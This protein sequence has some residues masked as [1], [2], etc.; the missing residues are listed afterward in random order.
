MSQ[1]IIKWNDLLGK[2]MLFIVLVGLLT[3][4]LLRLPDSPM[5]R[6]AVVA[7]FGYMT[8]VTSLTISLQRFLQ[9]LK[10]PWVPLWALCLIHV[11]SPLLAWVVG[12]VFYPED[13][14]TRLGYLICA[15]IPAGVTSII[16]TSLTKGNVAVSLVTVTL[17]TLIVPI[18][19]PLYL[20]F[21]VGQNLQLDYAHMVVQLVCMITLPSLLGILLH[22]WTD[23]RVVNFAKGIGGLSSK[24]GFFMVIVINASIVAPAIEWNVA[25]MKTLFVTLFMVMFSY[26]LGY[27]GTLCLK[28]RSYAM[29]TT[30]IY[31]VGLRNLSF[32]LVLALSY[33]PP[34]A[35]IPVTLGMLFQQPIAALIPHIYKQ[36][37]TSPLGKTA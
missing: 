1:H 25:L 19:M 20:R 33:F 24:L 17:D 16:W 30:M 34:A 36:P 12:Y 2:N 13:F 28:D 35:A 3:G 11:I 21:I 9:V 27:L 8:F 14:Y 22:D 26:F 37:D 4:F 5:L 23:G 31:N 6:F 15:A 18:L 32:G 7:L 29:T 10:H